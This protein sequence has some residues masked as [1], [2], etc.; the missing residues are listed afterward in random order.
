MGEGY[1]FPS[2]SHSWLLLVKYVQYICTN[3]CTHATPDRPQVVQMAQDMQQN[4]PELFQNLQEQ[5]QRLSEQQP[6]Q[7]NPS[8]Q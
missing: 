2:A 1:A 3:S 4:N 7:Q 6:S 8:Q 5:A